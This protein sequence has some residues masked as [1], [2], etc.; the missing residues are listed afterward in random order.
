MPPRKDPDP[1][2][3]VPCF[4]GA[5]LRYLR[6][7]AGLTL[8]QLVDGSFRGL[9]FLSQIERG[10]RGMPMDLAV[11][12]DKK[13]R[14]NGFFQRRCEDAQR[15]R[16]AGH[17]SYFADIPDLEKTATT[18]EEWAPY[19][20]PGL[21]QSEPYVRELIRAV[22][23]WEPAEA[24]EE[25]VRARIARATLW[26]QEERPTYWAIL[27]ESLI[28]NPLLPPA[29]MAEQLE[30]IADDALHPERSADPAGNHRRPPAHDRR[31]GQDH[32]LRR[33]AARGL[34]RSRLQ[35]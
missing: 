10:E 4:Y 2:A 31:P 14:T 11:H 29:Q 16:R 26:Q 34:G 33:C 21:L 15:A 35:R 12:V 7:K 18:I 27:R 1:S 22:K 24:A 3:S 25:T 30:H 13:L 5:E 17:P 19:V 32:D 8:E 9:S 28:R 6:E 23:P 20:I